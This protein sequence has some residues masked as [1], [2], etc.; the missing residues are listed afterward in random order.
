M[1]VL[2]LQVLLLLR[3]HG[4]F[5]ARMCSTVSQNDRDLCILLYTHSINNYCPTP[6]WAS[7]YG[8]ATDH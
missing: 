6:D 2:L 8:E 5:W 7:V 3:L 1:Q 4:D